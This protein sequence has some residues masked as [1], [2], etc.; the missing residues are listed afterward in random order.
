MSMSEENQNKGGKLFG[1]SVTVALAIG[2]LIFCIPAITALVLH[3][4]KGISIW[5][6]IGAAVAWVAYWL[7]AYILLLFS[8]WGARTEKEEAAKNEN[9]NPYS[10]KNPK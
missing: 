7:G 1:L 4:V 8:R 2:S 9:K 6:C 10:Q 5:W 3:F